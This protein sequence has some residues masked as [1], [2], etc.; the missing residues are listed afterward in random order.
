MGEVVDTAVITVNY[1]GILEV[2]ATQS[3]TNALT[4]P[5][6]LIG[7]GGTEGF[8][9]NVPIFFTNS[10]TGNVFGGV[11]ENDVYYVTTVID[12]QTF[13]M[14]ETQDP[15]STTATVTTYYINMSSV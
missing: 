13:T 6:N 1:P 2:T 4:V 11:I 10:E 8:Y 15:L 3:G 12:S 7:T 5:I 14:S 9:T